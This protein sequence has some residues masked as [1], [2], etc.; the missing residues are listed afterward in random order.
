MRNYQERPPDARQ[1]CRCSRSGDAVET[2]LE[3][4]MRWAP[5]D[6]P[7]VE[8]D[9]ADHDTIHP[10]RVQNHHADAEVRRMAIIG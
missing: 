7:A 1:R 5:P 3:A 8:T 10:P 6:A 9:D 2:S 4:V